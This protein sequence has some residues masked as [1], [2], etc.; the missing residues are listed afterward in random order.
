M[1]INR[2]F[3]NCFQVYEEMKTFVEPGFLIVHSLNLLTLS[4]LV[5]WI[6]L[7]EL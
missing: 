5:P 4:L 2:L 6:H 7:G 3:L 1:V